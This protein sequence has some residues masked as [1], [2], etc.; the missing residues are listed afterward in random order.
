M[1]GT[2]ISVAHNGVKCKILFCIVN[3]PPQ[4]HLNISKIIGLLSYV[5]LTEV[6]EEKAEINFLY[7]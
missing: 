3:N 5:N 2:F 1:T 4:P 6:N 7:L